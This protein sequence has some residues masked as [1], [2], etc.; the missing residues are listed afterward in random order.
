MIHVGSIAGN[1]GKNGGG[2][3]LTYKICGSEWGD[4]P[5]IFRL[6]V[7]SYKSSENSPY[8]GNRRLATILRGTRKKIPWQCQKQA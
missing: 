2:K 1:K 8:L 5:V 3:Y 4:G 6:Q 7:A